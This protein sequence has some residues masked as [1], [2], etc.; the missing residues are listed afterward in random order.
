MLNELVSIYHRGDTD[1]VTS[2]LYITRPKSHRTNK[3]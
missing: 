2:Q 1:L 3:G